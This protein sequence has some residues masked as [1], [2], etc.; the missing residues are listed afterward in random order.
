MSAAKKYLSVQGQTAS[1]ERLLVMLLEGAQRFLR[2]GAQQLASGQP[3]D[4][5]RTIGRAQ[6]IVAELQAT[7]DPSKA[8]ELCQNLANVYEFVSFQIIQ[9]ST[10]RDP[11]PVLDAERVLAPIVGAFAQAAAQVTAAPGG[12]HVGAHP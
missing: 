6:A 4:G 5:V 9:A 10:T 2:Q 8:P 12:G 11:R 7:L 1:R 3:L